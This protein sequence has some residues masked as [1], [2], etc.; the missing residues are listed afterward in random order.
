MIYS[1]D[2]HSLDFQMYYFNVSSFQIFNF[3]QI[4]RHIPSFY[5]NI[6]VYKTSVIR[7]ILSTTMMTL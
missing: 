1:F 5:N 2:F 7:V 4:N 6:L 3:R